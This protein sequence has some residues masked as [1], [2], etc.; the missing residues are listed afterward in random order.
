LI[1]HA[2]VPPP[3]PPPAPSLQLLLRDVFAQAAIHTWRQ[4]MGPT[5][6]AAARATH[7]HSIRALYGTDGAWRAVRAEPSKRGQRVTRLT[8]AALQAR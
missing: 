4:L 3:P 1:L 2:P 8:Y 6:S 5:N 7:P